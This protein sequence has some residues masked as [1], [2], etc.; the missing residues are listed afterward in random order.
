MQCKCVGEGGRAGKTCIVNRNRNAMNDSS[1]EGQLK[2]KARGGSEDKVVV[3]TAK[4]SHLAAVLHSSCH[5]FAERA[6]QTN[7][8][9]GRQRGKREGG[10]MTRQGGN[11]NRTYRIIMLSDCSSCSTLSKYI[12]SR[13]DTIAPLMTIISSPLIMPAKKRK[14]MS[15]SYITLYIHNIQYIYIYSILHSISVYIVLEH[16]VAQTMATPQQSINRQ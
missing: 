11:Y 1:T 2:G 14:R 16:C 5:L 3:A 9:L 13:S 15:Y 8:T 10:R 7:K 6:R 4:W 12:I